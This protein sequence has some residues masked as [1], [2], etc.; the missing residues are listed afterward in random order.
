MFSLLERFFWPFFWIAGLAVVSLV[1]GA[2][3][4]FGRWWIAHPFLNSGIIVGVYVAWKMVKWNFRYF[5]AVWKSRSLVKMKIM[6]PRSDT[7]VDTEKRTEKDF[8]EKV[9]IMEQLYRALWEVQSLTIWQELRYWFFRYITISF[10]MYVE[11]G[12]LMFYVVTQPELQSIVE[13]Q[14][15]AFYP[16]AEVTLHDTPD[17][18]P[19]GTKLTAYN[20]ITDKPFMFPLRYYEQM[21]DDPLNGLANVLSKMQA[22][23]TAGIQMVLMPSTSP[24]WGTRTKQYASQKFKGKKE[25]WFGNVPMLGALFSIL[26]GVTT[27]TE[28][29]TFAPGAN[30]GD[31]F[32]RMIQPEEELYKRMGEKAGM[33]FYFASIRIASAA[34]TWQRSIE[35]TNNLQVAFNAFKDIYGNYLDDHRM[36]TNFFPLKW[37]APIIYKLWQRRINGFWHP[38]CLLVEKELAGLFHF[39]DSRYNKIPII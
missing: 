19:K 35:I 25:G 30:R 7:K 1:P 10:E 24:K 17:L 11:K 21:Q 12:L 27:G 5:Y 32:V 28:G 31:A 23:E 20:M 4:A 16:N 13:K 8:K 37:N 29:E 39:P 38:R 3:P 15:T 22:D 26:G 9:A 18:W 36:F 2:W 33:S 14:I 34:K 6:L